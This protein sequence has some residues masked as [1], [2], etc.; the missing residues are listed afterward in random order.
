[1]SDAEQGSNLI[2]NG[3]GSSGGGTF[4]E[5]KINGQGRVDGDVQCQSFYTNGRSK[6]VGD[7]RTEYCRVNGSSTIEGNVLADKLDVNGSFKLV[8]SFQGREIKCDGQTKIEGPLSAE[9][10][11]T[12]GDLTVDANLDTEEFDCKG[13]FKVAGLLNAGK[14]EITL[15][16]A[17]EAREIGGESIRVKRSGVTNT[18]GKLVKGLF[19]INEYLTADVI[20][21]DHVILEGTRARIVRGNHVTIGPECEIGL[22]EYKTELH[23]DRN[24]TINEERRI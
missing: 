17:S 7:L 18:I 4:D 11:K 24:S 1:M 16:G 13:S 20:E 9:K 5:V 6:L 2:I 15:H 10:I 8:G 21:G 22:V 3:T 14:L 19:G 12:R 23:R